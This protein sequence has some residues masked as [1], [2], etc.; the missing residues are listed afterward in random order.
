MA[1]QSSS[2]QKARHGRPPGTTDKDGKFTLSTFELNDGA[3][4][5]SHKVT[6]AKPSASSATAKSSLDVK[7]PGEMSKM[8]L[9]TMKSQSKEKPLLPVVYSNQETTTLKADV[10]A[11]DNEPFV[12]Q[13]A[14]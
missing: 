12:F 13:L 5:G 2:G 10:K 4:A 9:Q 7:D 8:Y 3:I 1:P 6:V 14:D 11:G